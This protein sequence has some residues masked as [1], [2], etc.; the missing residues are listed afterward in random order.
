[1]L[2]VETSLSSLADT[3]NLLLIEEATTPADLPPEMQHAR[4]DLGAT[5]E[6][7]F[8]PEDWTAILA[9]AES[10]FRELVAEFPPAARTQAWHQVVR[11]FHREKYWGFKPGYRPPRVKKPRSLGMDFI[12]MTLNSMVIFKV[13]VLWFGQVYSRS[14]QAQ[15]KWIFFAVLFIAI[16]NYVYFLWRHRNYVD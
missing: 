12:I 2:P 15:D 10:R 6:G 7:K 1:M 9:R 16:A 13:V 11:E 8:S 4:T 3:Q 14:E 5:V